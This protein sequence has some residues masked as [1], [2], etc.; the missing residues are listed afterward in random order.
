MFISLWRRLRNQHPGL[1]R[2]K[3]L[4]GGRP[5]SSKPR[6]EPLEDR[7]LPALAAGGILDIATVP[8]VVS[9][10]QPIGVLLPGG[11]RPIPVTVASNSSPIVIDLGRVFAAMSGIRQGNGLKLS[12]LGNTNSG[13]VR[14]D[15]SKM[16][17]TLTF[18]AGRSGTATITVGATDS[19][20]V[21]V[22]Q[23]LLVT[24][25]PLGSLGPVS[26]A[27]NLLIP[28]LPGTPTRSP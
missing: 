18:T 25:A 24:V 13:L 22:Q 6:L 21:S 26:A 14:T 27:P 9:G 12:I 5:I 28:Q 17:L 11:P 3:S 7:L 16:A 19:D 4:Q 2:G 20:G 23:T 8:G 15:L 10:P 1:S